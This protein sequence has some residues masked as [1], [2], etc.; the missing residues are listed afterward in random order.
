MIYSDTGMKYR[1]AIQQQP[2]GQTAV[3]RSALIGLAAIATALLP[4]LKMPAM[5]GNAGTIYAGFAI[6]FFSL[7]T[8]R[9]SS[10][11]EPPDRRHVLVWLA[12]VCVAYPLITADHWDP[13]RLP[14]LVSAAAAP[15]SSG[16]LFGL[17]G[18]VTL[19]GIALISLAWAAVSSIR[20]RQVRQE[21]ERG[22]VELWLQKQEKKELEQRIADLDNMNRSWATSFREQAEALA[23]MSVLEERGRIAHEIHDVVGHTL[24]AAIVQLEAMKR[25]AEQQDCV[26]WDKLELLNGL[27]RKGLDDIRR[28][29]RQIGSDEAVATTL[30][31]SLRQLIQYAEDMMEVA[32]E[33]DISLPPEPDLGRV[34]EQML[35][36]A[37]QEGLTNGIR[38]GKC[39]QVRFS[40]H[41]SD[42]MLRFRLVSDGEPYGAAVPGF[43][44]SSMIDRVKLHGGGV[45][46][47]SSADDDGNPVGCELSIDLPL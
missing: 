29:V 11:L 6:M 35:Y 3:G 1:N 43:G 41:S 4:M 15:D 42:G 14:S 27:V 22:A 28:A 17:S 5:G 23:E 30:E 9:T 26:P 20:I 8:V 34:R 32:I 40:L 25:V 46:I 33:A 21:A 10:D 37:L 18:G 2:F 12:I 36:H 44:L 31:A 19:L 16:D 39:D 24:T 45:D 13:Y 47:R 7:Q 38:H